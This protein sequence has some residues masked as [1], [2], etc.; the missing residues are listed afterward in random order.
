VSTTATLN[1][2]ILATKAGTNDGPAFSNTDIT[3]PAHAIIHVTIDDQDPGDTD[4]PG[5]SPFLTV[6]GTDGNTATIDGVPYAALDAKKVAHTFTIPRLG[7][8]VPLPGDAPAGHKDNIVTF[9]F[10]TGAP[11]TYVF[12]CFDPCGSGA[13]GME[14]PMASMGYM[15]GHVTIQ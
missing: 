7:L 5:T 6:T 13:S 11:G 8:N 4:M 12:Q 2:T 1:L 10:R 14:G 9:T 15:M 3:L